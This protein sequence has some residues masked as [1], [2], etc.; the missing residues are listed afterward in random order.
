MW[1]FKKKT[2]NIINLTDFLSEVG[3]IATEQGQTYYSA[4]VQFTQSSM[5]FHAELS[6]YI[7]GND[8]Y[9]GKT[10]KQVCEKL[11]NHNKTIASPIKEVIF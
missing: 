2:P 10:I 5:G 4:R 9:S 11:R 3:K 6:G 8:W 7:H 1:P